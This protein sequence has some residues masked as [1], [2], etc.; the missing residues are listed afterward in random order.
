MPPDGLTGRSSGMLHRLWSVIKLYMLCLQVTMQVA[1]L[2]LM[3][4]TATRSH[5]SLKL[6]SVHAKWLTVLTA[7]QCAKPELVLLLQ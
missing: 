4:A 6:H 3:V 7:Y 5:A 1:S 2:S